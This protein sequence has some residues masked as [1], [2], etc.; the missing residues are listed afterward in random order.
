MFGRGI[1]AG[2]WN[3]AC[4]D[5]GFRVGRVGTTAFGVERAPIPAASHVCETWQPR[6]GPV[7]RRRRAGKPTARKAQ[8]PSGQRMAKKRMPVAERQQ[9]TGTVMAGPFAGRPG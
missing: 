3:A 1:G 4:G 9:E 6:W 5:R 8:F 7:S 2:R